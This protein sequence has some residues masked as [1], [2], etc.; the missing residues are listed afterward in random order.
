M[1]PNPLFRA[2]GSEA[3]QRA[4][5]EAL[6]SEIGFGMIF[7]QRGAAARRGLEKASC[8]IIIT[9]ILTMMMDPIIQYRHDGL[10]PFLGQLAPVSAIV[11]DHGRLTGQDLTQNTRRVDRLWKGL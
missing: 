11:Q 6:V 7:A 4:F 5:M 2:Q 1:H 10:T 9:V 3:E 8:H